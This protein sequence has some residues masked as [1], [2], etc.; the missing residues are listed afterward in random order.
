M[1]SASAAVSS[2]L[3]GYKRK[4]THSCLDITD[5]LSPV[6]FSNS[7][8]TEQRIAN[9]LLKKCVANAASSYNISEKSLHK[10][11]PSQ[12]RRDIIDDVTVMVIIFVDDNA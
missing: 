1:D 6:G 5:D 9:S 12:R 10:M 8:S 11:P 4:R 3:S 2:H 7:D